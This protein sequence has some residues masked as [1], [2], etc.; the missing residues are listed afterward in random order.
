MVFAR[1][2]QRCTGTSPGDGSGRLFGGR[3]VMDTLTDLPLVVAVLLGYLST[4]YCLG[5]GVGY[6]VGLWRA[7]MSPADEKD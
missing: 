4:I 7:V 5:F 3:V 1:P 2:L 6:L